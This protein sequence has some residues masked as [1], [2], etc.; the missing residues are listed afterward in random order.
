MPDT[1][2]REYVIAADHPSLA[3]HFPDDPIVP[4]VVILGLIEEFFQ[5]WQ[6]EKKMSSLSQVKFL[7]PLRPDETLRITLKMQNHSVVKFVCSGNNA[8][9]ASGQFSFTDKQ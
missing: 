4:G 5:Q 1:I 3:G 6:P 7:Q 9:L 2:F 8:T